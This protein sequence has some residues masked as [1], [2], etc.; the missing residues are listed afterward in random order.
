VVKGWGEGESAER[1]GEGRTGAK[2]EGKEWRRWVEKKTSSG[3][4]DKKEKGKWK[5]KK[6][7]GK[8]RVVKRLR[9]E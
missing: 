7:D 2:I 3:R 1:K 9:G 8:E 6:R 4:T 5:G